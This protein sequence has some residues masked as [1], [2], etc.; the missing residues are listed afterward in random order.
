MNGEM[1]WKCT[2]FLQR[3]PVTSAVHGRLYQYRTVGSY[4][5]RTR[6]CA[7]IRIHSTCTVLDLVLVCGTVMAKT[8]VYRSCERSSLFCRMAIFVSRLI[9]CGCVFVPSVRHGEQE[10][11][12]LDRCQ[13]QRCERISGFEPSPI[14]A[15]SLNGTPFASP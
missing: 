7:C 12:A 13:W 2:F 11:I 14:L 8:S 9:G 10:S 1:D 6:Y 15:S 3:G 4:G 5:T